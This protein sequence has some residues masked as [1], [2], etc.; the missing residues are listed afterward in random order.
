EPDAD[1]PVGD[2]RDEAAR[3]GLVHDAVEPRSGVG[4]PVA[5]DGLGGPR[6][7][8]GRAGGGT[9]AGQG[10]D[11]GGDVE[12]SSGERVRAG[13]RGHRNAG[14]RA[15]GGSGRRSGGGRRAVR[16]GR[17]DERLR[18][19]CETRERRQRSSNVWRSSS[20]QAS[21]MTTRWSARWVLVA[22]SAPYLVYSQ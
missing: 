10:R 3:V 9:G 18:Q 5:G 2:Q 1:P 11:H 14:D 4:G 21:F 8:V 20:P 7:A 16:V 6:R 19:G 15:R 12:R 22:T 13:E 17:R